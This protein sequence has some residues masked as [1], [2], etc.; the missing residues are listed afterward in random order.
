MRNKDYI[1]TNKSYARGGIVSTI[2][3]VAAVILLIWGITLA[4]KAK[5]NG[6]SLVGL[7]GAGALIMSL[8]GLVAGI[9]S[10]KEEDKFYTFSRWGTMICGLILLAM[11]GITVWG[12]M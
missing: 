6:D 9:R 3:G 5:G 1:F 12:L 11:T 2:L 8:A 10:F 7:L 4:Y